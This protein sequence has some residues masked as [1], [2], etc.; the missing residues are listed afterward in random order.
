[1]V[2]HPSYRP[3]IYKQAFFDEKLNCTHLATMFKILSSK[4]K[5]KKKTPTLFLSYNNI[6]FG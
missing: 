6:S 1:M 3:F 5:E 2:A 4:K